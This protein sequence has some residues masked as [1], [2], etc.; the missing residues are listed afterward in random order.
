M[1]FGGGAIMRLFLPLL[2]CLLALPALAQ[3]RHALVVGIDGY[4]HVPTL[5]KARND[6][7]DIAAA[8]EAAGFRTDL[9][10]DADET[11]LLTA[12]TVFAG[13]LDP[14]DEAVF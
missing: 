13:R 3:Q 4:Q 1:F 2:L 11:A 8:L 7:R 10:I 9:L 14:G 12:L 5:A 6:A